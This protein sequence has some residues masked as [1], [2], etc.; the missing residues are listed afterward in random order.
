M[1]S[2]FSVRL[3]KAHTREWQVLDNEKE[4]GTLALH[5]ERRRGKTSG[6]V[7][8]NLLNDYL[9]IG[10]FDPEDKITNPNIDSKSEIEELKN[11]PLP[12]FYVWLKR[13]DTDKDKKNQK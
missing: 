8:G 9:M 11:Q 7:N 13:D 5:A 12:I 1:P 2:Q 3:F 10:L 4:I 6:E